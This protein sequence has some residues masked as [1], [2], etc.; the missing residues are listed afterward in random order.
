MSNMVVKAI[1]IIL[2]AQISLVNATCW[3]SCA[4]GSCSGL[5]TCNNP[6]GWATA[7]GTAQ[8][9]ARP[10]RSYDPMKGFPTYPSYT[11][12]AAMRYTPN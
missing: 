5:G 1:L 7:L 2:I 10:L 8:R 11:G 12:A 4:T 3:G 6:L 9:F